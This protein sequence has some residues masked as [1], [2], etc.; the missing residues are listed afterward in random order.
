MSIAKTVLLG[1][2]AAVT[3]IATMTATP[4]YAQTKRPN[5]VVLMSDDTGWADLGA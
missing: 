2:P 4:T 1:L 3:A 5:V